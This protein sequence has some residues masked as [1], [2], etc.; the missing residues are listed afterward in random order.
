MRKKTPSRSALRSPFDFNWQ[1]TSKMES[2]YFKSFRYFEPEIQSGSTTH[3][4]SPDFRVNVSDRV[5]G[6]EVTR[7]FK[8][9]GRQDVESTQERILEEACRRAQEQELPPAQVTLFFNLSGPLCS[10][11]CTRIADAVVRVVGEQMPADGESVELERAPS[12]PRSG[13]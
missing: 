12:Q 3:D 7:L 9:E 11:A 1:D 6:V 4:D 8:P 10:A 5:V 13:A 2:E